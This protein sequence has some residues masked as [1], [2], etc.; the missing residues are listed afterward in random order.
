LFKVIVSPRAWY[1]FFD[2]FEYIAADN[3]DA[4]ARFCDSLL[5]HADLLATFPHLGVAL[6]GRR[7]VRSLLHTPVRIYYRVD[8]LRQS[9]E[10]IHIWH[11]ARRQPRF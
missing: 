1:D 7:G 11:S 6:M 10:I 4:A 3:R 5:N 2:I 8:D 9:I